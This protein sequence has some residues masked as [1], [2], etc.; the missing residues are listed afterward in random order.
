MAAFTL[1][2]CTCYLHGYDLTTDLNQM[3]LSLSVDEQDA[4]TFQ[5][6]GT[7][8]FRRRRAGL[9]DIE[10]S[11]EGYF[12]AGA[13]GSTTDAPDNDQL[14]EL[15][16]VDRVVTIT[17]QGAETGP[18]FI[19]QA[20]R[21]SYEWGGAIGDLLPFSMSMNGTNGVGLVRG[22]LVKARGDVSATGALGSVVN[23]TGPTS[24]QYV[25]CAFHVFD[26]GTTITVQLQSDTASNFPSPT[27]QATIGPLTAIGGTWV[28]R[29]AGPLLNEDYWRLNVS[30]ITGTFNV[31]GSIAV[32]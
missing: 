24:T 17:P 30:A 19:Y 8:A 15:G 12:Q 29:V 18:A 4:T 3:N 9:R 32:Q 20:G 5:P 22:Q 11:Y 14:T 16:V 1:L 26:A 21:F 31:A 10:S 6:A 23:I 25:Y 28:T 27:T 7:A 2:N 13:D